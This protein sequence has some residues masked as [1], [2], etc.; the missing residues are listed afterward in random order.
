MK[1]KGGGGRKKRGEGAVKVVGNG[2]RKS[3]QN[4]GAGNWFDKRRRTEDGIHGNGNW[5]ST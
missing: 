3:L 5:Q 1:V 4:L 2:G